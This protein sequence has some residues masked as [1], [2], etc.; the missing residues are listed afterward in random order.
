MKERYKRTLGVLTE[1]EI[2]GLGEKRVFVAGCGGLGGYILE[3]IAR[4]G[5]KNITL[6]D[7]DVFCE[8]NLNR[9][10]LCTE[11]NI[12]RT[13]TEAAVLRIREINSEAIVQSFNVFIDEQNAKELLQNHDVIM[14]ALDNIPSRLLLEKY[15][16][17]LNIPLI[18][19]AIDGW[20]SQTAVVMPGDRTLE[21]LY[22]SCTSVPPPVPSFTPAFCASLQVSEMVKLLINK[23]T[24]PRH[25]ILLCDLYDYSMDIFSV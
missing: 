13:K 24:L 21:K 12:G 17:K 16:E 5:I 11:N 23:E 25:H 15:A 20:F 4:L 14:D 6:A 10:I 18:H 19:G 3:M 22:Q 7:G 8:T 2:A 1:G 9:Q